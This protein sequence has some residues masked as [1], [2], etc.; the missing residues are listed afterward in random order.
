MQAVFGL[1]VIDGL[2]LK[3]SKPFPTR[4]KVAL[5]GHIVD[6]T[7]VAVNPSKVQN[8]RHMPVPINKT[9]LCSFLGFAEYYRQFIKD[10]AKI[11]ISLHLETY[12]NHDIQS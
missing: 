8:I 10:F 4:N 9:E 2:Q 5:L 11:P 7:G 6:H 3:V 12:R 1:I